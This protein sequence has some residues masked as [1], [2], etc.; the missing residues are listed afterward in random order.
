MNLAERARR[1]WNAFFFTGFS[2]ESLGLLRVSS[3]S[4]VAI[5]GRVHLP[6]A[7]V[8]VAAISSANSSQ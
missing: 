2:V 5:D 3:T 8:N 4:T 1:S 6:T 7:I